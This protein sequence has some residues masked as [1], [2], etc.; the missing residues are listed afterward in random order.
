LENFL[1]E[2]VPPP[3]PNVPVLDEAKIG[4]AASLRDQMEQHRANPVCSSCHAKMDPVGFGFENFNAIGQYRTTDGKFPIDSSGTL[5]DGRSFKGPS[6]LKSLLANDAGK[7]TE[8]VADKML[9][10]ALGRGLERYDRRTVKAIAGKVAESDYR[11]SSLVLEIV[12]SLPF[13][14]ARQERKGS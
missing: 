9:T 4:A 6:D 1:N 13:Q 14:M 8:C 3:P 11:F 5:P 12:N 2:P 7:F 10:Y